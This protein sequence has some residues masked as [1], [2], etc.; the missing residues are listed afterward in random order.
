[1]WA[2]TAPVWRGGARRHL[3]R[4]LQLSPPAALPT[5]VVCKRRLLLGF[6]T[7]PTPSQPLVSSPLTH[8]LVTGGWVKKQRPTVSYELSQ[9]TPGSP[10][11]GSQSLGWTE[12]RR[13][14][15]LSHLPL[16]PPSLSVSPRG[17]KCS[18]RIAAAR[19][20]VWSTFLLGTFHC[21]P[22]FLFF[23]SYS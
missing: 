5:S 20:P 14:V 1:M 23:I 11:H 10:A 8:R 4:C 3:I 21:F 12:G 9:V 22:S 16:F 15:S 2:V 6:P 18:K 17:E 7:A 13:T 19:L